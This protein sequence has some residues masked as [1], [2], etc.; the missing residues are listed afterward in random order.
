MCHLGAPVSVNLLPCCKVQSCGIA[1]EL[2][3]V[4]ERGINAFLCCVSLKLAL[5]KHAFALKGPS[6]GTQEH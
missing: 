3:E 4:T 6:T 2:Q 5:L 1:E